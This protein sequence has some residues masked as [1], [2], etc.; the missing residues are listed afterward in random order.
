MKNMVCL[1]ALSFLVLSS[2]ANGQP[3]KFQDREQPTGRHFSSR[4]SPVK[5]PVIVDGV[6]Y[7]PEEMAAFDGQT[8]YWVLD[9]AAAEQGIL[10]AFTTPEGAQEYG[11][12]HPVTPVRPRSPIAKI[13]PSCSG[14]N[15]VPGCTGIDWLILCPLNQNSHLN[16][17]WN[18][19]ISCV[20]AGSN[21]YY[22]V[23]YKCYYFSSSCDI[24]WVAS[25]NTVSDLNV[26]GMNNVVSSIRFCSNVDPFSCTQ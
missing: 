26:Y 10:Y 19:R 3:G 6:R 24:L 7:E 2:V 13:D 21:G 17:S 9:R 23:L 8:M 1:A 25:G 12:E 22:T 11:R 15:K 14:F 5:V 18:D 4:Q 16:D 20:E